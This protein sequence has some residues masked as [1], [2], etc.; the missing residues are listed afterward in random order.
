M[1]PG[2]VPDSRALDAALDARLGNSTVRAEAVLDSMT[3]FLQRPRF[4]AALFGALA[5]IALVLCAVGLYAVASFEVSRR[6]HEMGLRLAL[7]ATTRHLRRVVIRD[8]VRPV[9]LGVVAGTVAAFWAGQFLQAF[10]VGVDARDPWTL[11]LVVTVLIATAV[12]AAW[13][14]ARRASLV[15]PATTLRAQ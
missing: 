9:V 14:P 7:G 4:Q 13:L 6:R 15:D 8:A 2:I 11:G 1:A 3:P 12:A 10:L 5:A